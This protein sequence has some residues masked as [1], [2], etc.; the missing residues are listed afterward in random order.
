[1]IM[2]GSVKVKARK[3]LHMMVAGLPNVGKS[4]ILNSLHHLSTRGR[5]RRRAVVGPRPGVTR[6]V[7]ASIMVSSNLDWIFIPN[8]C[9]AINTLLS[10]SFL[11]SVAVAV[12]VATNLSLSLSSESLS[13]GKRESPSLSH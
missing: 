13:Q 11:H 6:I 2:Q 8:S 1:M 7:S 5:G 4:T 3:V 9:E 10:I 12:A